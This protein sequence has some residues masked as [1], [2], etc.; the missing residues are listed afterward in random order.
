M[1]TTVTLDDKLLKDAAEYTGLTE[2]S[3]ILNRA[4]KNLIEWEA[5]RRLALLGGSEPNFRPGRRNYIWGV[6][7][8]SED[9]FED[10]DKS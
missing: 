1:R 4:L 8:S 5:S 9:E 10:D 7:E 3:A 6:E 2:T